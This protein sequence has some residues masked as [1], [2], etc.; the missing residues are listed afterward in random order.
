ME[1]VKYKP[2]YIHRKISQDT[3]CI[4]GDIIWNCMMEIWK[5]VKHKTDFDYW[6]GIAPNWD[7]NLWCSDDDI[8][9]CTVYP[10]ENGET[11]TAHW[12]EVGDWTKEAI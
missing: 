7:I 3:A 6:Y 2:H 5:D 10:V 4:I 8:L 9:H 12:T 1:E 11:D